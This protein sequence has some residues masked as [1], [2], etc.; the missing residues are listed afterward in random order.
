ME[1]RIEQLHHELQF[2]LH[3][4]RSGPAPVADDMGW[5]GIYFDDVTRCFPAGH[6]G[7]R[8]S[9][10]F[11]MS[12]WRHGYWNA[13]IQHWADLRD[14]GQGWV[15]ANTQNANSGVDGVSGEPQRCALSSPVTT[16]QVASM[17]PNFSNGQTGETNLP[18]LFVYNGG[19]DGAGEILDILLEPCMPGADPA[20]KQSS[21]TM[22]R[23]RR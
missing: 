11:R 2:A 3:R 5:K 12:S 21:G 14:H 17:E 6:P 10:L 22:A 8:G 23:R 16:R 7:E 9:D 18:L 15:G 19:S 4:L 13:H 20:Y 1:G